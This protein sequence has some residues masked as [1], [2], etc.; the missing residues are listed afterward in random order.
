MREI[1]FRQPLFSKGKFNQWHNWGYVDGGF[2]SPANGDLEILSQQYIGLMD[3]NGKE[4]YEGD[5]VVDNSYPMFNDGLCNY[6]CVVIWDDTEAYF[7]LDMYCVSDRVRGLA[8][9]NSISEYK[10]LEVI[11]NVYEN[12]ELLE[13]EC[14][15]KTK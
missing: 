11:G 13:V 3:K 4:I 15:P 2:V 10:Q 5:I 7:G 8:C 1:K 14:H 9:P 12:P 6:R